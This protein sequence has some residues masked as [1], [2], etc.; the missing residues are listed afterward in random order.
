ML[1]LLNGQHTSSH[2]RKACAMPDRAWGP[3]IVS[4]MQV[5]YVAF[6]LFTA[7][8]QVYLSSACCNGLRQS[9]TLLMQSSESALHGKVERW[10]ESPSSTWVALLQWRKC[11]YFCLVAVL[12]TLLLSGLLG[13]QGGTVTR[14]R[15]ALY[16]LWCNVGV[17]GC[18]DWTR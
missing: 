16:W 12:W 5:H 15:V 13:G 9:L 8:W 1:S 11:A 2:F 17:A 7:K 3:V 6:D 4:W 14:G 10:P 18:R